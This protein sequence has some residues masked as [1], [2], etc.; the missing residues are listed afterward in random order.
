MNMEPG[1]YPASLT[2]QH[3]DLS[4]DY[5]RHAAHIHNLIR[6]GCSG[7]ALFGTTGEANSFSVKERKEA[8]EHLVEAGIDANRLLVGTGCCAISDAVTLTQHSCDAGANHVLM[9]PPFYYKNPTDDGLFAYYDQVIQQVGESRLRIVLYHFPKMSTVPLSFSLIE[10]LLARYPEVI[11]GLK[12][13][14]GDWKHMHE[15]QNSFPGFQVFAGTERYLLPMLRAGGAG[16]ITAS[17]NVTAPLAVDLFLNQNAPDA[18]NRQ[19]LLT[20]ARAAIEQFPMIPALKFLM[21]R[22]PGNHSWLNLRP[23]LVPLAEDKQ[24]ALLKAL[25]LA[26]LNIN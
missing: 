17:A 21:S 14:S 26:P 24:A 12:D 5:K 10:R 9:L 16:C 19:E 22:R 8:L 4:I 1:V 7:V 20:S 13:S 23:P 3:A 25:E 6:A 11:V 2:P 18:E 15:L